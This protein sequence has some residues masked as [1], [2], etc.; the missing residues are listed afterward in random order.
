MCRWSAVR[1]ELAFSYSVSA[2]AGSDVDV[3]TIGRLG[4][5]GRAKGVLVPELHG[6]TLEEVAQHLLDAAISDENDGVGSV[7]HST[8][9]LGEDLRGVSERGGES[10]D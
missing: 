8:T 7:Y 3:R 4:R 6:V 10:G 9:T 1:A 5:L 2:V